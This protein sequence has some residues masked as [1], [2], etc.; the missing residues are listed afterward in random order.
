MKHYNIPQCPFLKALVATDLRE[1]AYSTS[2]YGA[3][4]NGISISMHMMLI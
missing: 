4:R 3:K 2:V 1:V